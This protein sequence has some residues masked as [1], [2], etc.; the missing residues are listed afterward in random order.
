MLT[1]SYSKRRKNI[2]V[3]M[4]CMITEAVRRANEGTSRS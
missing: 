2:D 1:S 3:H 4:I